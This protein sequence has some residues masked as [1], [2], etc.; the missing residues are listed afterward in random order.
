MKQYNFDSLINRENTACVKYDLRKVIFG[1]EDVVPMW[2]ADMDIPTP[3]FILD[4]IQ[5]RCNHP[6][7]G[8]TF[9]DEAYNNAIINWYENRHNWK[10]QPGWIEFCPGVVSGLNHIIR[11]YTKPDD[12]III[13]PPVYHPFFSTAENNG[14]KLVFNPL[15]EN[16]GNYS[17]NFD[18]LET[19]AKGAKMLILSN[20]H[21]PVGRVWTRDELRRVGEICVKH[22]VLIVSDEIHSDLV[23]KPFEHISIASISEEFAQNTVTFGSSSKTFNIAGLSSGFV[24]IPNQE[25]MK[26]YKHELEASG[27][28]MGNI[29]GNEALKAA[30]TKQG[31]GW[32]NELL[33]YFTENIN[34]VDSTLKQGLPKVKFV[35][36]QGTYL[37]WIDFR[38][39]GIED[40]TLNKLLINEAGL[41]FNAGNGFG[42]EGIGFQRI[43]IAC[44]RATVQLALD[45]LIDT[46]KN[47]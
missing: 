27:A 20:P 8:Y 37:L 5:S 38:A 19:V 28:G 46:F 14:R 2:V 1:K 17:I 30:F 35:K 24:I 41:G 21:N 36:P 7:L 44:P 47:Y 10:I 39:L 11:A 22:N 31:E 45:R 25:L 23:Y 34:L 32:L 3:N 13:Q 26:R 42:T 43:N 15:L 9:R 29:F 40:S 33:D 12:R 18:E 16:D 6:F 4:A